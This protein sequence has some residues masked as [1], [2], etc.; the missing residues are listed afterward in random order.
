MVSQLSRIRDTARVSVSLAP[1]VAVAVTLTLTPILSLTLTP[2]P[3]LTL[4]LKAVPLAP[5]YGLRRALDL[6]TASSLTTNASISC[7]G[8][9]GRHRGIMRSH[10]W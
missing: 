6:A 7:D 2:N 4:T 5:V 8:G 9:Q 10:A 3:A 1:A